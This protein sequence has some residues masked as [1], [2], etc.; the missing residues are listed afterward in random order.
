MGFREIELESG[1]KLLL[2]KDAESNDELMKRFKGKANII[3]HTASPGSPFGVIEKLN[4][5][6]PE[7]YEASVFVARYSQ[8]WR[9]NKSNTK[10]GV[11]TGKD[12]SK[13]KHEKPG[14]WR[15]K[16][17]KTIVVKKKDILKLLK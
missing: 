12:I 11:F 4:P 5:T 15:V 7:I 6:K 10:V 14:T 1:T 2:G 13:T 17:S 16:K 3:L 9:D 8:E